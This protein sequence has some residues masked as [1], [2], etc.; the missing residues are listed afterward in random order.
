MK[1]TDTPPG[2]F[3]EKRDLAKDVEMEMRAR[4]DLGQLDRLYYLLTIKQYLLIAYVATLVLPLKYS[5]SSLGLIETFLAI[6]TIVLLL[7]QRRFGWVVLFLFIVGVPIG[8]AFTNVESE[9]LRLML[10]FFPFVTFY[11][12]G[13]SLRWAVGN[14]MSD[15]SVDGQAAIESEDNR[16]YISDRVS[17]W[18]AGQPRSEDMNNQKEDD[19]S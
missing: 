19:E 17:R 18:V 7:R 6:F 12:Y 2:P 11:L 16:I 3:H 4:R 9:M 13:L 1:N 15:V 10:L 5:L 8:L 14:W